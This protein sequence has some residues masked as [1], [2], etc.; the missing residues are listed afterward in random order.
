MIAE[1][2][3]SFWAC[4]LPHAGSETNPVGSPE[5]GGRAEAEGGRLHSTRTL[6]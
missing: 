2:D 5:V 1:T 4:H 6:G 3:R